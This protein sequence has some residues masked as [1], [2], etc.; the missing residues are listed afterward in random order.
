MSKIINLTILSK[1]FEQLLT[2]ESRTFRSDEIYVTENFNQEKFV[3]TNL[4]TVFTLTSGYFNLP[5]DKPDIVVWVN[6]TRVYDWTR[7]SSTVITFDTGLATSDAVIIGTVVGESLVTEKSMLDGSE[8]NFTVTATVAEIAALLAS[9]SVTGTTALTFG[10]GTGETAY[11]VL[12]NA[13]GDLEVRDKAGTA[14][15]DV[16]AKDFY[17]TVVYATTIDTNVAAAAVTMTATTIA[18]DGTDA[19]IPI[20]IT[21][22]GTG[23]VDISNGLLDVGSTTITTAANVFTI[24]ETDI[25]LAGTV[26][27]SGTINATTFDTNVAAAGVTLT[28]TTL[29]ADG[30][31]ADINITITPKGVGAIVSAAARVNLSGIAAATTYANNAAAKVGGLVDGDLYWITGADT[32]AIVH[33]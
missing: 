31:D 17:G 4:Q 27:A 5:L 22:K 29:A 28:G 14:F 2:S 10:I 16:Y 3:A 23:V 7:T 19:N 33:A 18:A 9:T 6:G 30:T 26:T 13:S 12:T 24:T 11:P 1:G 21:S 25:A 8:Q 15:V 32:L 20:T